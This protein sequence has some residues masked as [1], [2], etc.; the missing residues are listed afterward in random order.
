MSLEYLQCDK[1]EVFLPA[2]SPSLLIFLSTAVSVSLC[3]LCLCSSMYS[4][5]STV[6]SF[7]FSIDFV[8]G[9]VRTLLKMWHN[10]PTNWMKDA[11]FFFLPFSPL[12]LAALHGCT[13]F[14]VCMYLSEQGQCTKK[15]HSPSRISQETNT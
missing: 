1:Y 11:T 3:C 15:N 5:Y 14:P 6:A 2:L 8:C 7:S 12:S 4:S 9:C 13:C 10:V